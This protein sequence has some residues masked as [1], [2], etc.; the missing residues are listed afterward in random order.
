MQKILDLPFG[1][2]RVATD[3]VIS[4]INDLNAHL[5]PRDFDENV[6]K[7]KEQGIELAGGIDD[8]LEA[9]DV[10]VD[11]TPKPYGKINKPMYQSFRKKAIYQGGEKA[12]VGDV[13]FVAQANFEQAVGKDHVRVV[14]CN[15]TGLVRVLHAIHQRYRMVLATATL[16]RRGTDSNDH[17]EGPINAII[18][19]LEAPSHHGPDVRSV[20]PDIDVFSSAYVVPTTLMH[21]HDLQINMRDQTDVEGVLDALRATRR[22]RVIPSSAKMISTAQIMDFARDLGQNSRGD[23]MDICV[24]EQTVGIYNRHGH[25]KLFVKMAVHQESDVIPENIDAI[26]AVTGFADGAASMDL[27]DRTL[28]LNKDSGFY[29]FVDAKSSG[30]SLRE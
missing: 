10:V 30:W 12:N 13:S 11:C 23:M 25:N 4:R 7:F 26:R 9:C 2:R 20:M 21:V 15:T 8:L 16:I 24:W 29:R 28:N 1:E 14:S 17:K 18:P 3:K 27:T 5:A 22:V 6:Q 19:S